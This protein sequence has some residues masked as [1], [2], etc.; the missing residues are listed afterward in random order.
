MAILVLVA[1]IKS[2]G[3]PDLGARSGG[4]G[5]SSASFFFGPAAAL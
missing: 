4:N 1:G 2:D 3:L 5:A